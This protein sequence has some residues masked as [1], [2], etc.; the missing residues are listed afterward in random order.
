MI[1]AKARMGLVIAAMVGHGISARADDVAV[2]Q[3][4]GHAPAAA[5]DPRTA[6]L[7]DA[8]ARAARGA[9]VD[10]VTGEER[11]ARQSELDREIVSRARRWVTTFT[12]TKDDVVEGRRELTV[13]V[14][15]DRDKL[16]ERLA[17]LQIASGARVE[18]SPPMIAI[19]V[20]VDSQARV[21]TAPLASAGFE[22]LTAVFRSAGV[23]V[24]RESPSVR[25]QDGS[26]DRP[27]PGPD[28]AR[29][30]RPGADV[31]AMA[32]VEMGAPA[33]VRGQ[34]RDAVLVTAQIRLVE[35]AIPP[36]R[37]ATRMLAQAEAIAA[38][39]ANDPRPGVERALTSAATALLPRLPAKLVQTEQRW[40]GRDP[41]V[42][43]GIVLVRIPPGTPYAMVLAE[44]K[45]LAAAKG[46]RAASL[47]RLSPSGWVIGVATDYSVSRVSQI[48]TQPP[49]NDVQVSVK[50]VRGLVELTLSEAP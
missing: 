47:R 11:A 31:V 40:K 17:Q 23:A 34:S 18:S 39:P 46:I 6:A 36:D 14:Q 21:R 26:G 5:A 16:R 1:A 43:P 3:V 32:R 30:D 15:I 28:G 20:R 4:S 22:Q 33:R 38:A 19:D 12:V 50:V 13:A 27:L 29:S 42:D 41:R 8:F 25:G 37:S 10:L 2:Y 24:R 49:A 7:D 45:F 9:L 35:R 44:Q 48:V